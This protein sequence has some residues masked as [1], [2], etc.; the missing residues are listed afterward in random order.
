MISS[1]LIRSDEQGATAAEYALLV[2]LIALV[3][4]ASVGLLG[5]ELIRLF[6]NADLRAALTP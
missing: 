3:I 5:D 2:A 6:E 4:F 1:P